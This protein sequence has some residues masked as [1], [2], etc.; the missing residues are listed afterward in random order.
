MAT[1]VLEPPIPACM[2]G[3]A[4]G[5]WFGWLLFRKCDTP[6][7][8]CRNARGA[9]GTN[10]TITRL[11]TCVLYL[12]KGDEK[13]KRKEKTQPIYTAQCPCPP[14][15]QLYGKLNQVFTNPAPSFRNPSPSYRPGD[16]RLNA[17][18]LPCTAEYILGV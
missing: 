7:D 16:R 8:F 12:H 6:K 4:V 1:E 14:S 10:N 18:R 5:E 3:I 11:P 2:D 13:D 17:A 15:R 9:F